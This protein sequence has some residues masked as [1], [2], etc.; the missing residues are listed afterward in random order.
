MI[1]RRYFWTDQL[2]CL[3]SNFWCTNFDKD[4]MSGTIVWSVFLFYIPNVE[5]TP[6]NA[7]Q[8][9]LRMAHRPLVLLRNVFNS[10]GKRWPQA[11]VYY[12]SILWNLSLDITGVMMF[13]KEIVKNNIRYAIACSS[14]GDLLDRERLLTWNLVDQG[15]TLEKLKI[16]FRKFY[17][18]YNDLVQHFNT[19]LSQFDIFLCL[20]GLHTQDLTSK[21]NTG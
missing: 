18:R 8:S 2:D 20:C 10:G 3:W 17:G 14:C 6:Y 16:Y 15:Y 1:D 5:L 4:W 19:A 11:T 7:T 13:W 12:C 9:L 21:D